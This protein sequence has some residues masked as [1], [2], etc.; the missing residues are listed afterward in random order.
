MSDADDLGISIEDPDDEDLD[1][2]DDDEG[3]GGG[4]GLPPAVKIAILVAAVA[5]LGFG[6]FILTQKLIIP[7]LGGTEAVQNFKQRQ[8]EKR[9]EKA[10]EEKLEKKKGPLIQHAIT[11]FTVNLAGPRRNLLTFNLQLEIYS[12][13][14]VEELTEKEYLIRDAMLSYFGAR[15]LQEITTRE[16][17]VTAKD[18]IK[19]L[20][21]SIVEGEPVDAVY[22]TQFLFQ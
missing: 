17:M 21:N 3:D 2:F 4:A 13:D 8:A 6:A 14:A 11:G 5:G 22:F 15:T 20:L 10:E 19:S 12:E 9:L 18:T 7:R 16:F 1:E